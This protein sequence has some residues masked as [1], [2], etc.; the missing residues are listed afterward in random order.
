MKTFMIDRNLTFLFFEDYYSISAQSAAQILS[1]NI[2]LLNYL[3]NDLCN[4][5]ASCSFKLIL[6]PVFLSSRQHL[7]I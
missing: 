3:I 4:Y 6:Y 5:S 2:L 1:L 7:L